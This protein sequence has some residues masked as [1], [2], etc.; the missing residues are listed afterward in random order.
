MGSRRTNII[1]NKSK[2]HDIDLSKQNHPVATA[3]GCLRRFNKFKNDMFV[4]LLLRLL[5]P[6]SAFGPHHR[7]GLGGNDLRMQAS[8]VSFVKTK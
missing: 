4:V 6:R 1:H 2:T 3:R 8:E 7:M 5:P